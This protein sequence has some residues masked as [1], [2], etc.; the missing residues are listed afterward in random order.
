[1]QTADPLEL[2]AEGTN[3]KAVL[4]I[5]GMTGAPV[6]MRLVARQLNRRGYTVYAPLLAGHGKDIE[7]LRRTSWQD[8]LASVQSAAERLAAHTTELFAAGICAG[9][10][11]ALLTA[12]RKPGL[13]RAVAIYSPCFLYDGWAV[14]FYLSILGRLIGPLSLLP[15]LDRLSISELPTLGIKDD[16]LRELVKAMSAEGV[17]E[18]VPT[19]SF[20]E[21]HRLSG[22]LKKQ[23]PLMR[24][25]TLILHAP[26]DDLSSPRHARYVSRRIGAPNE[27]RWID[28]SYH[29]IHIDRQY[30]QV[31]GCTAD[32]FEANYAAGRP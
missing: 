29:M 31:A 11:L 14:P 20:R 30:H 22:A 17:F 19:Q 25:P 24:T 3:G 1:M 26:E 2:F 21:M 9:G 27:L 6:E 32:F 15:F 7:E 8:C 16:R 5:H 28:D 18:K 12:H 10:K 13:M 23:L 4:L